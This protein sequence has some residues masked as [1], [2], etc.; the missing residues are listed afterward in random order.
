[1]IDGQARFLKNA[2]V[3]KRRINNQQLKMQEMQLLYFDGI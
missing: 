2:G 1:M 3:K